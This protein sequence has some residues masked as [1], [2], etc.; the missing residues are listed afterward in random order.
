[1]KNIV[2][3]SSAQGKSG[4]SGNTLAVSTMSAVLYSIKTLLVQLDKNSRPITDA[5]ESGRNPNALNEEFCFYNKKG[6]DELIDKSKMNLIGKEV[7]KDN[8]VHIKN[9]NLFYMPPSR[10]QSTQLEEDLDRKI[11]QNIVKGMK[12]FGAINFIDCMNGKNTVS[13][14]LLEKGDIIVVN[15]FQGMEYPEE[16]LENPKL[17]EKALFIVGRYDDNSRDNINNIKKKY[18]ISSEYIGVIPYNI[19]FHDAI[20]AGRIVPFMTR[21]IFAKKTDEDFEFI[22][23]VFNT[24]NMILRKAGYESI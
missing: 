22:N 10:K 15:M 24:T 17:R 2:F 16:I 21:G 11:L 14:L 19:H 9:T 23:S 6:L 5:F 12:D 18:N 7:L 20:N 1:M 4:T 3:W 8:T 13:E